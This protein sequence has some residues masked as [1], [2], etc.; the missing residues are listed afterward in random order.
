MGNTGLILS[1]QNMIPRFSMCSIST[2]ILT[3]LANFL[4]IQNSMF[5]KN[6]GCDRGNTIF[7]VLPGSPIFHLPALACPDVQMWMKTIFPSELAC[8][9]A[10]AGSPIDLMQIQN[11]AMCQALEENWVQLHKLRLELSAMRVSFEQWTAVL[12]P[13][14]AYS[15]QT[16]MGHVISFKID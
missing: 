5:S 6:I 9:Q 4:G 1:G 12:S 8:L 7:Q 2:N 11:K 15:H 16:Y 14:K 3:V 10:N 13:A